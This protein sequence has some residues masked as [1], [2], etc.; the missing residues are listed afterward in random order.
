LQDRRTRGHRSGGTS[1]VNDDENTPDVKDNS[2]ADRVRAVKKAL[3]MMR[4]GTSDEQLGRM[5][6]EL[7]EQGLDPE[8]RRKVYITALDEVDRAGMSPQD[9]ERMKNAFQKAIEIHPENP[10]ELRRAM[11]NPEKLREGTELIVGS[12]DRLTDVNRRELRAGAPGS[13]HIEAS[14]VDMP[15]QSPL[16]LIQFAIQGVKERMGERMGVD[17]D[18]VQ[19]ELVR[20][21][22]RLRADC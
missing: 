7:E 19:K 21:R 15:L 12:L 6:K 22:S 3:S 18:Q 11:Q 5:D 20:L 1:D 13:P 14:R 2:H 10:H 16:S 4:E 17:P 8:E 9:A